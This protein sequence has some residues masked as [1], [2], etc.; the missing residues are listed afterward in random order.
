MSDKHN[1]IEVHIMHKPPVLL[2]PVIC[3]DSLDSDSYDEA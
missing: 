2:Q 1:W 3:S